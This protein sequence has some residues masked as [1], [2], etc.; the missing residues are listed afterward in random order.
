MGILQNDFFEE[1]GINEFL[2]FRHS[3]TVCSNLQWIKEL[4]Q[5]TEVYIL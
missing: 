5:K 4:T 3:N 1:F 2:C